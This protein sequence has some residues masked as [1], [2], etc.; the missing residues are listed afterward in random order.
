MILQADQLGRGDFVRIIRNECPSPRLSELNFCSS[1]LK[2][3][4]KCS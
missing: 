4:L 1:D 2:S 3:D